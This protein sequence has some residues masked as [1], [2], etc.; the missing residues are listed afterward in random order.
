MIYRKARNRT[1]LAKDLVCGMIVDETAARYKM[2]WKGVTYY[3]CSP[4]C[5][6]NF[7]ANPGKYVLE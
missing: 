2:D 3:F 1:E 6:A 7:D 4:G 5:L